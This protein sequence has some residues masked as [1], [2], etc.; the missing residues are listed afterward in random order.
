MRGKQWA[1]YACQFS[2][3][4]LARKDLNWSAPNLSLYNEAFTGQDKA[5][6]R[7]SVCLQDYHSAATTCPKN[8]AGPISWDIPVW[9]A[10]TANYFVV[11]LFSFIRRSQKK[12]M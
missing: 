5:I 11:Q 6:P 8:P 9:P 4:G 1:V 12:K 7:C 2:R 10:Q 3:E